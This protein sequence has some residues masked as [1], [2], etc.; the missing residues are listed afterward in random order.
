MHSQCRI[1]SSG[2]NRFSHGFTLIELHWSSRQSS[3]FWPACCCRLLAGS[4]GK[5]RMPFTA[6]EQPETDRAIF[7]ALLQDNNSHYADCYQWGWAWNSDWRQTEAGQCRAPCGKAASGL[8]TASRII[9][10]LISDTNSDTPTSAIKGVGTIAKYNGYNPV[11]GIFMCPSAL[12]LKPI[13][14]GSPDCALRHGVLASATM[15]FPKNGTMRIGI[16]PES[17]RTWMAPE[18]GCA[19]T[20]EALMPN[21]ASASEQSAGGQHRGAVAGHPAFRHPLP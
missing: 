14:T 5:R 18:P 21:W 16:I 7:A 10:S 3:P 13:P 9:F 4:Q 12:H 20:S 19:L 15:E 11:Q 8:W 6:P 17:V 1:S 2:K